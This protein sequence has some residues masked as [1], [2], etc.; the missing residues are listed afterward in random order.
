LENLQKIKEEH[1]EIEKARRYMNE[2][3]YQTFKDIIQPT[4]V[5]FIA[6]WF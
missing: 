6:K 4:I 5:S 1:E 3:D 2:S